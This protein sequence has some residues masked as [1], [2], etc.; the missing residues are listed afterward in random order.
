M[1]HVYYGS[2][3]VLFSPHPPNIGSGGGSST[4]G[5]TEEIK[6]EHIPEHL[7]NGDVATPMV[8]TIGEK[9][10]PL[11]DLNPLKQD[12]SCPPMMNTLHVKPEQVNTWLQ[13]QKELDLTQLKR[14]ALPCKDYGDDMDNDM[15]SLYDTHSINKWYG[16]LFNGISIC[17]ENL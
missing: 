4:P 11:T 3:F 17:V 15:M 1:Q 7:H 10:L 14:P 2:Y 9:H 6:R 8:N 13:N 12:T 5:A 16:Y